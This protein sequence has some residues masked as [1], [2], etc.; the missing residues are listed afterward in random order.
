MG[1]DDAAFKLA[2][3]IS[4]MFPL[5]SH[6]EWTELLKLTDN[7]EEEEYPNQKLRSFFQSKVA[8]T[9]MTFKCPEWMRFDLTEK[10]IPAYPNNIPA[11]KE[12]VDI[13]LDDL[14]R[15]NISFTH[16]NTEELKNTLIA[17]YALSTS[18]EKIS[19]LSVTKEIP[20]FD[21]TIIFQEFGPVNTV[22]RHDI[23]VDSS[24]ECEKYGG[25]RMLLCNEFEEIN[26]NGEIIDV[27]AADDLL[28]D[29]FRG[30]CDECLNTIPYKHYALREPLCHGGWRGCYCSFDCLKKYIDDPLIAV[31][32][33]RIKEQL[34]VI[35]IRDR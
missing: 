16:K 13:I 10:D 4:T 25:C 30:S 2:G 32:I 29:W 14:H 28:L 21:D 15:Q 33:G 3:I 19:I 20:M 6:E 34:E 7:F 18:I 24:H 1:D 5:L 27:I 11:V 35:G 31:M 22:Y 26:D 9:R 17:Q 8:E 12:A 23:N